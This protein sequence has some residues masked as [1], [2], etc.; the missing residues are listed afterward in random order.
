MKRSQKE[1]SKTLNIHRRSA[2]ILSAGLFSL[3][4]TQLA[5]ASELGTEEKEEPKKT[6]V[7]HDYDAKY[8]ELT[9]ETEELESMKLEK[10]KLQVA[11][12]KAEAKRAAEE[13]KVAEEK[14]IA[15]EKRVAAEKLANE[16]KRIAKEKKVEEAK[17]ANI[18]KEKAEA[19][20]KDI[21]KQSKSAVKSASASTFTATYFTATCKGCS[22][23]TAG[24]TNIRSTIY[25]DGYR[26][27]AVDPSVIPL[28]T[29]VSVS[30][31][32]GTFTAIAD[33][34]G[35]A[36][37][38]QKIDILVGSTQEAIQLG[39]QQVVLTILSK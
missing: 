35:G 7:I 13:K 19:K 27:I 31:P 14:R 17:K 18:A 16:Q 23:I 6:V 34:V 32:N 12:E 9:L 10:Y 3:F 1:K 29:L 36:I 25:K 8:D 33:D 39:R 22:G 11:E 24:G 5:L 2:F 21:Q 30:T 28:G 26:I 38:G 15:E 20:R 4:I 37:K